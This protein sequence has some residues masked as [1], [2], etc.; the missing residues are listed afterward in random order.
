[1]ENGNTTDLLIIGAGPTGLMMAAEA[2]RFGLS[3]RIVDRGRSFADLSR[4]VAIQARTL[5][6]FSLMGIEERFLSQG[7]PIKM[8]S[9]MS[10]WRQVGHFSFDALASPFPFVL[11]LEQSKTEKI[12][13]EHVES[14][15]VKI[16]RGVEFINLEQGSEQVVVH[17]RHMESGRRER[18]SARWVI[19]C[20]GAHS[21][22]R[23]R[24]NIPFLGKAFEDLY[25]LADVHID[26]PYP[27]DR[28]RTFLSANGM[29][30]AMP[31][32]EPGRYRLFFQLKRCLGLYKEGAPDRDA[33]PPPTLDEVEKLVCGYMGKNFRIY[34]PV[35]LSHFH[36]NSRLVDSYRKGRVFLAGDA[37]HIHSPGGGQGMNA[38]L[39][40]AHNLAWK[41]AFVHKGAAGSSLLDSYHRERHAFGKKLLRSTERAAFYATWQSPL[42]IALRNA[43]LSW[44]LKTPLRHAIPKN[45]SQTA[46]RYPKSELVVEGALFRGGPKAGMRAPNAPLS[47]GLDLFSTLRGRS[48]FHLLIFG[49]SPCLEKIVQSAQSQSIT[50]TLVDHPDGYKLYGVKK[51]ALY[52]IRPD[53]Y[54]AYRSFS[55]SLK[56]W[57][58][59][60]FK[61]IT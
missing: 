8:A 39:Q 24:L 49:K 1:M 36:I 21:D 18:A 44:A 59:R 56:R 14:L 22:V 43:L 28:V 40:D 15:G 32:P 60:G 29:L 57:E 47:A 19:G 13:E 34:D 48:G 45:L 42:A 27:H 17:L 20:D 16:E 7:I 4:A 33:A 53:G 37:A 10:E 3:S 35:W 5:E 9:L 54:I 25:S 31:L 52:L 11:S 23:K 50:P 30:A 6:I 46:I 55:H 61:F 26:W 41:L 38:G 51:R 12:L 58:R 2:K